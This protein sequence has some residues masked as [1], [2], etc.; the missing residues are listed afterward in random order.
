M[1]YLTQNTPSAMQQAGQNYLSFKHL[2]VSKTY[3]AK[4]LRENAATRRIDI[5]IKFRV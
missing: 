5:D 3:T 4:L 1:D 2:R